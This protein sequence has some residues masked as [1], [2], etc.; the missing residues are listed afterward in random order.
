MSVASGKFPIGTYD[1]VYD[2][3]VLTSSGIGFGRISTNETKGM[4]YNYDTK[5]LKVDTV[6]VKTINADKDS[7]YKPFPDY[8]RAFWEMSDKDEMMYD[9]SGNGFGLVN[10]G[11]IKCEQNETQNTTQTYS[12]NRTTK[13]FTING[14]KYILAEESNSQIKY[15]TTIP[16]G[17]GFQYLIFLLQ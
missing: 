3:T 10:K 5:T 16:S 13:E 2:Q 12:L 11:A 15:Y 4:K 17:T 9:Y 7:T 14:T 1:N 8:V 6:N